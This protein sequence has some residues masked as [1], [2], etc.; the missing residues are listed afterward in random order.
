MSV[1]L[2][3]LIPAPNEIESDDDIKL[4]RSTLVLKEQQQALKGAVS[5]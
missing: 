3:Q 4:R 2:I 1:P 5:E